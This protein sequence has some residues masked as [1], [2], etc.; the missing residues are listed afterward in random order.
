MFSRRTI[1]NDASS[2]ALFDDFDDVSRLFRHEA[3]HVFGQMQKSLMI[4]GI[5]K[6]LRKTEEQRNGTS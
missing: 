4:E 6:V 1:D 5:A 2:S 3:V